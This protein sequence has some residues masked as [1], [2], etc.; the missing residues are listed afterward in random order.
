M[1]LRLL[2]GWMCVQ[3]A[4]EITRGILGER[5]KA[6]TAFPVK[7]DECLLRDLNLR[8]NSPSLDPNASLLPVGKP[9]RVRY[10]TLGRSHYK[11]G[12]PPPEMPRRASA[13]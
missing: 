7:A 11:A 3:L 10:K 6:C 5:E 2:T 1:S 4:D 9:G 12:E 13:K 8:I